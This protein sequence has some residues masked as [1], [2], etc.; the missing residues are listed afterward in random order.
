MRVTVVNRGPEAA[1]IHVLP[2]LWASNCWSW[3]ED[4]PRPVLNLSPDG[5]VAATHP[6]IGPMR[7]FVEGSPE[8]LFCENDTNVDRLY[9]KTLAGPFKAGNNASEVHAD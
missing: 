4:A 1:P 3:T 5:S 2:H 7:L 8:I 9:G 6:E